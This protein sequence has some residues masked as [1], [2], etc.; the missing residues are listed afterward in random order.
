MHLV[1]CFLVARLVDGRGQVRDQQVLLGWKGLQAPSADG[2]WG[3]WGGGQ[4]R[5][6]IPAEA[7]MCP[8][9]TPGAA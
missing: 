8:P 9:T 4:P 2:F 1:D 5:T 6:G 7:W 3:P